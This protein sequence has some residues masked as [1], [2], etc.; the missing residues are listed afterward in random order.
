[1]LAVMESGLDL[2]KNRSA[3][4]RIPYVRILQSNVET[5]SDFY[6]AAKQSKR[7]ALVNLL[8]FHSWVTRILALNWCLLLINDGCDLFSVRNEEMGP[9]GAALPQLHVPPWR[10]SAVRRRLLPQF[11]L[12]HLPHE[13]RACLHATGSAQRREIHRQ[14]EESVTS[15]ALSDYHG[16]QEFEIGTEIVT[17]R[18]NAI[19]A[20][21]ALVTANY[22]F[23]I[24]KKNMSLDIYTVL[25]WSIRCL[26]PINRLI[27]WGDIGSTCSTNSVSDWD[28]STSHLPRYWHS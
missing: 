11:G 3:R 15:A 26:T 17:G 7:T 6:S 13:R 28:L 21:M 9:S 20:I 22:S 2:G 14:K 5:A 24:N 16:R 10:K 4:N 8:E 18:T 1:M 25:G 12:C 19:N 23:V 27:L